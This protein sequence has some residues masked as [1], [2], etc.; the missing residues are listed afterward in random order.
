MASGPTTLALAD[1][2]RAGAARPYYAAI[3]G[4]RALC[5]LAIMVY[6]A[7]A[8]WLP[9]G[10]LGV[11]VFFVVSGFLITSLLRMEHES[12]GRI[13]F[14]AFLARRARRLFPALYVLLAA[15]MLYAVLLLPD[16]LF[17]LRKEAVA[18][19]SYGTNWYLVWANH[20]YFEQVGRPS[21]LMHLWS[22]AV[23][24]QFYLAWPLV[25]GLAF[26]RIPA[27]RAGVLTGM[28]ACA[29]AAWMYTLFVPD[30]DP[31]RVYYGSDTR[32]SG[33]L[34]G[35][36]L[37]LLASPRPS[38]RPTRAG[39]HLHD[40]L[41]LLGLTALATA[42]YFVLESDDAPYQGAMVLVDLCAVLV[43]LASLHPRAH[44]IRLLLGNPLLRWVGTRSYGLYLWHWP[45]FALTRPELD[46]ALEPLPLLGLRFGLS[47]VLAELSFRLVEEPVRSGAI[48]R[49]WASLRAPAFG[50]RF[51][52][53]TGWSLG[54]L[55]TGGL[56]CFIAARSLTAVQ[57]VQEVPWVLRGP[58]DAS[59]DDEDDALATA[60]PSDAAAAI[61][62]AY[63]ASSNVSSINVAVDVGGTLAVRS[64]GAGE[65][66]VEAQ[67]VVP[68]SKEVEPSAVVATIPREQPF[69]PTR[70]KAP[71][72]LA[73][74]DSVML[75][76]V[77][78]LKRSG[79]DV[80]V[81]ARVGRNVID[82]VKRLG[83]RKAAGQL[84]RVVILHLGNNGWFRTRH[85]DQLMD[86]LRD[87]PVV[88]FLTNRVPRH[89]QDINN[90]TILEGVQRHTRVKLVDW[91]GISATH[92][93]WFNHDGFHL[94]PPG[95]QAYAELLQ[96][97]M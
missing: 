75:G 36:A 16:E 79:H 23:E 82:G 20:S 10:F 91:L 52:A 50:T 96:A 30:T 78:Y 35:A 44:A 7:H 71:E 80:E 2:A 68:T 93:D 67:R 90:G 76:A 53:A 34:I 49:A 17:S 28:L 65:R 73:V 3:D 6:H 62:S 94:R 48:A 59:A 86:I 69:V 97:V 58:E 21:L 47:F 56:V 55:V 45:V 12:T 29:S 11:E 61:Q 9:G 64:S 85:F 63:A 83:E 25:F 33:L 72:I 77:N 37:A 32:A 51:L 88:V 87:V 89:W 8:A 84:G 31:S 24:E 43:I 81:D 95:A 41:G 38:P 40:A 74:G 13:A 22:L 57:P 18:G 19:L 5:V 27:R 60:A 92:P 39:G 14:G 46:V 42:A 54:A 15:T 4:L 1:G 66:A 70:E 26:A